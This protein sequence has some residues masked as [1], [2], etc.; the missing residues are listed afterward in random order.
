[1]LVFQSL[2]LYAVGFSGNAAALIVISPMITII[3]LVYMLAHVSRLLLKIEVIN[4]HRFKQHTQLYPSKCTHCGGIIW[5]YSHA[6]KRCRLMVHRNC[7]GQV[8]QDC[9]AFREQPTLPAIRNTGFGF[10]MPHTFVPTTVCCPAFCEQC[11]Q[12]AYGRSMQCRHC[13]V[14]VHR[15]C[16]KTMNNNGCGVDNKVMGIE[17]AKLGT[18]AHAQR[19]IAAGASYVN[20]IKK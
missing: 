16:E 8:V 7:R 6:C 3:N 18:T 14:V 1:M 2:Y 17:L 10:S 20:Y 15:D 4:N 9:H 12:I 13:N 19:G 5:F 11:G